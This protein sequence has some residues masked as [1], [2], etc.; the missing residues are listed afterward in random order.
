MYGFI[1]DGIFE[2]K[3]HTGDNNTFAIEATKR[4]T[5]VQDKHKFHSVIYNS[6]D[7]IIPAQIKGGSPI[8]VPMNGNF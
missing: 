2:G 8:K 5:N 1:Y 7:V 6:K 4:Y 3:I